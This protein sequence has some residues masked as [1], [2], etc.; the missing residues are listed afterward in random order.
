MISETKIDASLHT[1]NLLIDCFSQ[2]YRADQNSSGGAIMLRVREGIPYLRKIE[3]LPTEGLYVELK[4]RK[5]KWLINFSYNPHRNAIS[6]HLSEF[7]DFHSSSFSN[8]IIFGDCNLGV[9]T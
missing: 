7:L 8:I 5:K 4:L 9:L 1:G 3:S 6:N 2:P